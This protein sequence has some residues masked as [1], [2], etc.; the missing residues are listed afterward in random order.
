VTVQ[1]SANVKQSGKQIYVAKQFKL[2]KWMIFFSNSLV[3][4]WFWCCYIW[5]CW[6]VAMM[7]YFE[8]I[9]QYSWWKCAMV[10]DLHC[11]M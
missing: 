10:S 2:C 4:L 9:V 5:K 11:S 6:I 8:W 7:F 3:C 1:Q